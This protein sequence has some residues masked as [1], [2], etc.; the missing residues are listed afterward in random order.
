MERAMASQRVA[1]QRDGEHSPLCEGK[2][3]LSNAA[4][5]VRSEIAS[6]CETRARATT[7]ARF[8][9]SCSTHQLSHARKHSQEPP[10]TT[11]LRMHEVG[12]GTRREEQAERV[13][14]AR[15]R[16]EVQ[17]DGEGRAWRAF[18]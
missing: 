5:K 17:Q 18:R 4:T 3:S 7:S 9:S 16:D 2:A 8:P 10:M 11:L 14:V 6:L 1:E 15:Q 13:D 12:H